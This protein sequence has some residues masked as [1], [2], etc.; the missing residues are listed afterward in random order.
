M[1]CIIYILIVLIDFFI[2]VEVL[3]V[4]VFLIDCFVYN[5]ILYRVFFKDNLI[6]IFKYFEIF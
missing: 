5:V 4:E 2:G 1:I 3:N 6:E